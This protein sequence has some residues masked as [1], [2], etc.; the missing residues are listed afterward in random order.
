MSKKNVAEFIKKM[1]ES[2]DLNKK[3]VAAARTPEAWVTLGKAAGLEYTAAD[4]VTVLSEVSGR[5]LTDKDAV[6]AFIGSSKGELSEGQ[7]SQVSGGTSALSL[8][9]I[10]GGAV[11]FSPALFNRLGGLYGGGPVSQNFNEKVPGGTFFVKSGGAAK[12]PSAF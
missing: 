3:V 4:V 12:L 8:G 11:S 9:G 2:P 10:S 5:K 7:L 1:S 6:S